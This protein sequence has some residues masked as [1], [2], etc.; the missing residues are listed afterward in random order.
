V[1]VTDTGIGIPPDRQAAIFESFTQADGSTNRRFGGTGLGLAISKQLIELMG[2]VIGV[3]SELDCGSTFWF[4]LP[5]PVIAA[6]NPSAELLRGT[7]VVV[8]KNER[9]IDVLRTDLTMI[10][11]EA[12][13][14]GPGPVIERGDD[15]I[16]LDWA[17]AQHEI[18]AFV[19]ELKTNRLRPLP[20]LLLSHIGAPP[21][22]DIGLASRTRLLLKPVR[23][24]ELRA[25]IL[26]LLEPGR[27]Q[28]EEQTD[29]TKFEGLRVLVAEDNEINRMI[30]QRLLSLMGC[31]V[32]L[33][34]SGEEAVSIY[35]LE[36]PEFIFMDCQMP[37]MD[38]F[39][40]TGRIRKLEA[41]SGSRVP[42][43]AMTANTAPS[44]REA[45]FDAGMD[46]FLSKPVSGEELR[47]KMDRL[48]SPKR[49]A[50]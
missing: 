44:D 11:L 22:T 19:S 35:R 17:T 14:P 12:R 7:A 31:V 47:L 37:Y 30:A 5:M 15:L 29:S 27:P 41:R 10:G 36:N 49:T 38:G 48:L 4:E 13:V 16:I 18:P 33:A 34:D 3:Q 24:K 6:S 8:S 2:G 43:V 50:G 28:V 23:K 40:A 21:V 1:E 39:E 25:A 42:I 45:C 9:L 46:D 26:E 20:T 32:S